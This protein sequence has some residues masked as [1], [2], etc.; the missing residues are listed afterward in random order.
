MSY[1]NII[2]QIAAEH[3]TTPEQVEADMQEALNAAKNN[4]TF[5][6]VFGGR[7]P[8]IEEF[9]ETIAIGFAQ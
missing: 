9:I 3:G 1:E 2:R 5:K 4:P 7:M 6:V 8:T